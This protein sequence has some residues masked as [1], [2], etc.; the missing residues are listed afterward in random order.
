MA[1]DYDDVLDGMLGKRDFNLDGAFSAG[2]HSRIGTRSIRLRHLTGTRG[3]RRNRRRQ[4][5]QGKAD[6]RSTNHELTTA[7]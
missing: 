5:S 7:D 3:T 4:G 2:A 1:L 6:C